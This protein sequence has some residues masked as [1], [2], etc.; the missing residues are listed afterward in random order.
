MF[1][2]PNRD[3]SVH[4]DW[5]ADVRYVA[6]KDGARIAEKG[7]LG[8]ALGNDRPLAFIRAQI[9]VKTTVNDKRQK[10]RIPATKLQ[11][12]PARHAILTSGS[13]RT[14]DGRE[15]LR[16]GRDAQLL[17]CRPADRYP[18]PNAHTGPDGR[19]SVNQPSLPARQ[20]A[21]VLGAGPRRPQTFVHPS[22]LGPSL[23]V[24]EVW[25]AAVARGAVA[26]GGSPTR[27]SSGAACPEETPGRRSPNDCRS[28]ISWFMLCWLLPVGP[29]HVSLVTVA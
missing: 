28:E 18:G 1:P 13:G 5:P 9:L 15:S 22:S 8:V 23:L 14:L 26:G 10:A 3:A 7:E 29:G 2:F 27:L 11:W 17:P 6:A 24:G 4:R 20:A 16:A 21:D 25:V 19:T 12:L